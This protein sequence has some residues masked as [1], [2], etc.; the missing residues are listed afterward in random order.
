MAANGLIAL[1]RTSAR[2]WAPAT[3]AAARAA[4]P[5][6]ARAHSSAS[7][8]GAGPSGPIG[9]ELAKDVK[10]PTAA[11]DEC[12]TKGPLDEDDAQDYVQMFDP[13]TREW[14]GPTKGGTMPEPTRYGD[15]ERKG[16]CTDFK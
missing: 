1:V 13:I 3:C 9:V 4:P 2:R 16:R 11:K 12:G 7:K 14:G 5:A 8:P 10:K 6:L 15:W